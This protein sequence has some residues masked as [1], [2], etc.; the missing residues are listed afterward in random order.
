[1]NNFKI[2]KRGFFGIGIIN[3]KDYKNIGTL[4]RT[5]NI[6]DADFIFTI[7]KRY[8][9]QKSDTMQT[10]KHVPMFHFDTFEDFVQSKPKHT[11]LIGV[12]LDE[13]AKPLTSFGH[14][15]R[16]I[17]LLGAED[18][19]IPKNILNQCDVVLQLPGDFC[20]NVSTAGSIVLYDRYF[21]GSD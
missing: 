11:R 8:K 9:H 1:M 10:P 6:F 12:E 5:A 3:G 13:R 16:A 17:Y 18:K 19:G 2:K 4:W 15:E 14:F 21:K 7:G 20:M